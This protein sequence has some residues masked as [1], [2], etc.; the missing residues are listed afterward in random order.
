MRTWTGSL[1]H[2]K[3]RCVQDVQLSFPHGP[4]LL[5]PDARLTF[6]SLVETAL[7]PLH[8]RCSPYLDVQTSD[9]NTA[10]WFGALLLSDQSQG[11]QHQRP[12][13]QTHHPESRLGILAS[14]T[15]DRSP[16]AGTAAPSEILFFAVKST[17]PSCPP[18]PPRS[19]DSIDAVE[20]PTDPQEP[21]LRVKAVLL[22][23]DLL[24]AQAPAQLTP[25]ASPAK[26]DD[27]VKA[28][29]VPTY[30]DPL[31][32]KKRRSLSDAFDEATKRRR[33]AKK[34]PG[35]STAAAASSHSHTV[36]SSLSSG[37]IQPASQ[38]TTGDKKPLGR[39]SSLQLAK[40][41][42]QSPAPRP[43]TSLSETKTT[44]NPTE[45]RNRDLI[46]RLTLAG[47][48]LRGLHQTKSRS[49]QRSEQEK[50]ADEDFKLVYHN[51]LKAVSFAFRGTLASM[52]LKSHTILLQEKVEMMLHLFCSDPLVVVSAESPQEG[53]TPSGRTPFKTPTMQHTHNVGFPF[54]AP[55]EKA[56]V[57]WSPA[58]ASRG[59]DLAIVKTSEAACQERKGEA[60]DLTTTNLKRKRE[61]EREP[62]F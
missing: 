17:G 19:S 9:A 55:A 18:T 49:A 31:P 7:L 35:A 54:P 61:R 5:R 27:H 39:A 34:N 57:P 25:P 47:M 42:S 26:S 8:I 11:D 33:Q 16:S 1:T 45:Q 3:D 41:R 32:S 46:S 50:R 29:F 36:A 23:S 48:R 2:A 58:T 28:I 37:L 21:H 59:L 6:L 60:R 10:D 53:V 20:H 22:S 15:Q 30:G 44:L 56:A 24:K 12:W 13:W 51:T 14:I 43:G 40:S 62:G 38:P 4:D 52:E